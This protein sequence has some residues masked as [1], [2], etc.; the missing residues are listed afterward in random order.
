MLNKTLWGNYYIDTKA[1]KVVNGKHGHGKL[2]PMFVQFVLE[3]IWA[4]YDSTVLN[5]YIYIIIFF[6]LIHYL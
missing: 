1:K 6:L 5:Q 3:N 2:K 4:I